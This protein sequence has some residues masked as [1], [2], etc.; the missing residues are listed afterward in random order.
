MQIV[1]SKQSAQ[2]CAEFCKEA[3]TSGRNDFCACLSWRKQSLSVAA[4]LFDEE[5]CQGSA[6]IQKESCFFLSTW[7][8]LVGAGRFLQALRKTMP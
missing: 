4:A 1:Q 2:T 6:Y 3:A 7:G 8:H 5:L